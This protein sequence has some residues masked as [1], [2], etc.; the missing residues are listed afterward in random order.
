MMT[1]I[2]RLDGKIRKQIGQISEASSAI[3]ELAVSIHSIEN[4]TVTA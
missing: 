2:E 1:E 3:E 4:N